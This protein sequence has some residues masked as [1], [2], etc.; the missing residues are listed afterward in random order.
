MSV[1][2][3]LLVI[4]LVGLIS[5]VAGQSKLMLTTRQSPTAAT[6]VD[7]SSTVGI[8]AIKG[9]TF[10]A[11]RPTKILIHGY[12]D[13]YNAVWWQQMAAAFLQAEDL[14]VFRLDW[15]QSFA[16]GYQ[17]ASANTVTVGAQV[18][19]AIQYLSS[20]YGVPASNVYVIG[21][22][23]GAQLAGSVGEALKNRGVQLG[24]ITGLDPAG[25]GFDGAAASAKLEQTDARFVDTIMTNAGGLGSAQAV[26]HLNFLPNGGRVQPGCSVLLPLC[27]HAKAL[28]IVTDSITGQNQ[29]TATQC[30]EYATFQQGRCNGQA[31]AIVGYRTNLAAA[32]SS[33][34]KFYS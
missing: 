18:A 29:I 3:T 26:G 16:G 5:C 7:I 22:S 34:L 2:K 33:P 1:A 20:A 14:N 21:H 27:S 28:T 24:R 6:S 19:N 10:S 17:Q 23:L 31:R 9:T 32:G 15:A 12:L 25:P 11:S 30:P 8:A 4:L 13:N